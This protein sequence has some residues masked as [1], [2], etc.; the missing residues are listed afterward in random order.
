VSSR[1]EASEQ[2]RAY[3]VEVGTRIHCIPPGV[4]QRRAA[5]A[6]S[7][8]VERL[9]RGFAEPGKPIILTIARPV[10]KK[11]IAALLRAYAASPALMDRANL[12]I[13]AGQSDGR[14]DSAEERQVVD[15]LRRLCAAPELRH[16]VALPP[17]HGEA[18]SPPCTGAPPLEGSS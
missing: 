9:E 1:Q 14:H 3:G 4:P 12:V 6:G 8:L 18:M 17:T 16:R 15:E 5:A 11:N 7:R 13:L 10:R 2:V